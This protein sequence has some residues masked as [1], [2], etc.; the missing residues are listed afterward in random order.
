MSNGKEVVIGGDN[1]LG[2]GAQHVDD[3]A[4]EWRELGLFQAASG[5]YFVDVDFVGG[6]NWPR[7][8]VLRLMVVEIGGWRVDAHQQVGDAILESLLLVLA[9]TYLMVREAKIR[10]RE[11]A[12]ELA[13]VYSLTQP[14]PLPRDLQVGRAAADSP[15]AQSRFHPPAPVW[16]G[17][18]LMPTGCG[19]YAYIQ[20]W[21]GPFASA[22]LGLCAIGIGGGASV[23][24]IA[25]AGRFRKQAVPFEPCERQGPVPVHVRC[26]VRSSK[27][28]PFQGLPSYGLIAVLLYFCVAIPL[29]LIQP[30]IPTGLMVHLLRPGPAAPRLPGMDPVLVQVTS[31][32]RGTRHE[33]YVNWQPVAWAELGAVVRQE[34]KHRPPQWPVYVEGDPDADWLVGCQGYR[35]HQGLARG[36]LPAHHLEGITSRATR[37]QEDSPTCGYRFTRSAETRYFPVNVKVLFTSVCRKS[38]FVTLTETTCL[39]KNSAR[40]ENSPPNPEGNH[41]PSARR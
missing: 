41:T 24:A 15:A 27:R 29:W 14:G 36:S 6:G 11:R 32:A 38:L 20:H 39:K 9:G 4:A 2:N 17:M 19:A 18:F 5:K 10:R 35:H 30:I 7:G 16:A 3:T 25:G 34:L 12:A 37:N 23:L 21:D 40:T 8:R 22:L 28:R 26:K 13:R 33:V 31:E 1:S